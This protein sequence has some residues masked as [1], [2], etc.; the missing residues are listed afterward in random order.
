M[1]NISISDASPPVRAGAFVIPER[2][3]SNS[4]RLRLVEQGSTL[5]LGNTHPFE[6]FRIVEGC[7]CL[8]LS[9][10]D[11]RRQI[12]DVLGPGRL[13]G[14]HLASIN[15]CRAIALAPTWL[16]S[17]PLAPERHA[18]VDALRRMLCRAQSHTALL[19]RKTMAERVAAALLDLAEQ[20]AIPSGKPAGGEITFLLYLTRADLADWLG[21]TLSTVSRCLNAF[22]RHGLIA[23]DNPKRITIR[24][25]DTLGALASGASVCAYRSPPRSS[26]AGFNHASHSVAPAAEYRAS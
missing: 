3:P 13:V 19:G 24:D 14:L 23:F 16:R 15:G 9:L 11:G 18:V 21:L 17:F 10:A 22:K 8:S 12:L 6:A 7:I 20:F 25:R 4:P 5:A 2:K 26:R 1:L